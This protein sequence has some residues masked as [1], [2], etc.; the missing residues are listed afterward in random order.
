VILGIFGNANTVTSPVTSAD[1]AKKK[2]CIFMEPIG[3]HPI[4]DIRAII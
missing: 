2:G 3:I 4:V 1:R